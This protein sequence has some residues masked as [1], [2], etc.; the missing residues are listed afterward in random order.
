MEKKIFWNIVNRNIS[1]CAFEYLLGQQNIKGGEIVYESL[2]LQEFL[3]PIT[4]LSISD[5]RKIFAI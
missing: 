3:A 1:K 5:K 4:N 2:E